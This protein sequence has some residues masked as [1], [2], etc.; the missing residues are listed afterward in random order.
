M[1]TTP[2]REL[3]TLE[4]AALNKNA[5]M[6]K[7]LTDK[8]DYSKQVDVLVRALNI[9][10]RNNDVDTVVILVG[11]GAGVKF[12]GEQY[13]EGI[14]SPLKLALELERNEIAEYM[15]RNANW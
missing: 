9:A 15:I 12:G 10:V 11:K 2:P 5:N 1:D 3:T 7:L 14:P 8:L 4:I 6:V 13:A